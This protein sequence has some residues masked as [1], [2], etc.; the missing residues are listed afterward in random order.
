M[1]VLGEV[2]DSLR[3]MNQWQLLLA[4]LACMGYALSQ[5]RLIEP[6]A[7]R[8]AAALALVAAAGFAFESAEWTN[9]TMLLAFAVAGLGLFIGSTWL[10]SR[11]L[12]LDAARV[13][14]AG[15]GLE[16]PDQHAL[17]QPR[18]RLAPQR[19]HAVQSH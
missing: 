5:G 1:S 15:D 13:A 12:G 3:F 9:A 16:T 8:I 4:F 10:I 11:L 6:Q 14:V 2:F 19:K 17:P 7:R 18:P